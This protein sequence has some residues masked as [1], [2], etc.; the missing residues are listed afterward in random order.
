[1]PES[2][3]CTTAE[4]FRTIQGHMSLSSALFAADEMHIL[5]NI[6]VKQWKENYINRLK[7]MVGA[8]T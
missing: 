3:P 6:T 8:V 4:M 1:M 7:M 2:V 5:G